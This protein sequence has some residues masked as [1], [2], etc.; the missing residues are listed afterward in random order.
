MWSCNVTAI[1]NEKGDIRFV[2]VLK[3]TLSVHARNLASSLVII[4]LA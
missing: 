2:S 4:C 3:G 1:D